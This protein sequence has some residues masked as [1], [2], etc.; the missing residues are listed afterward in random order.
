VI[1]QA[2]IWAPDGGKVKLR[3]VPSKDCSM[4]WNI[5]SG[6]V[7]DVIECGKE[8]TKVSTGNYAGYM[9]TKYLMFGDVML[10]TTEN[11]EIIVD[12]E[13]LEDI[14]EELGDILGVRG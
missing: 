5:P 10:N 12:R 8:W 11:A 14:Y 1:K 3:P 6:A 9:K 13:R 2:T 7:V 4:Y